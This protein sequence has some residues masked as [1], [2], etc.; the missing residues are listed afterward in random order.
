MKFSSFSFCVVGLLLA[1]SSCIRFLD[2]DAQPGAPTYAVAGIVPKTQQVNVSM[3]GPAHE[4]NFE[5]EV[6]DQAD[7]EFK[8]LDTDDDDCINISEATAPF[9]EN[10]QRKAMGRHIWTAE[11]KKEA[12]DAE[13][14]ILEDVRMQFAHA[15]ADRDKCI[16]R[17][18]FKA[19]GEMEG[20]PPGFE[21]IKTMQMGF[22]NFTDELMEEDRL[23]FNTM[24]RNHD[25]KVSQSEAYHFA[26]ENMPQADIDEQ[27]LKKVFESA[28]VDGDKFIT[29]EEF[30][31][32]GKGFHGDGNET[33][34][35]KPMTSMPNPIMPSL[36]TMVRQQ[37][38]FATVKTKRRRHEAP[39]TKHP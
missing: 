39:K 22:E 12:E 19:V 34:M 31:H 4:D 5:D 32:A 24:D 17:T 25:G 28:D 33:Q 27:V 37:V 23:E 11:E 15:D 16:N 20:P 1:G 2:S 13:K 9:E 8:M 10:F 21:A 14:H 38:L 30:V 3:T 7:P 36:L 35:V 18:E 6:I 26:G 29:F